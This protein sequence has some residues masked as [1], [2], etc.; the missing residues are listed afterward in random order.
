MD[1]CELELI[2]KELEADHTEALKDIDRELETKTSTLSVDDYEI[3]QKV[4]Q[5]TFGE[6]FKVRHKTSKDVFALKRLKIEKE[7]EGF[8]ITALREVRILRSLSHKNIVSLR[9]ICH[10]KNSGINGYRYEFYL[11]NNI[12]HRD[13]KASNI[14]IDRTGTLKIADFGLARLTIVPSAPDRRVCYTGR[15]VTLWATQR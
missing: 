15:V 3:I 2:A 14:L 13:L 9:G 12:L 6:V 4:G 5:G 11:L 7:T 1:A 10:R 8:P